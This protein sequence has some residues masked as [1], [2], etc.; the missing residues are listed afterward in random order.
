MN[1]NQNHASRYVTSMLLHYLHQTDLTLLHFSPTTTNKLL[2]PFF[3]VVDFNHKSSMETEV[4][5]SIL[6]SFFIVPYFRI[7]STNVCVKKY[8]IQKH[9]NCTLLRKLNTVFN[10]LFQ[11]VP[12]TP[13]ISL[14]LY[15]NFI[16]TTNGT[17]NHSQLD[18]INQLI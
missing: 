7:Y 15:S 17:I 13:Q 5:Y 3:S 1:A 8:I 4:M 16:I 6:F 10:I 12:K 9:V 18:C 11:T 14:S 2:I